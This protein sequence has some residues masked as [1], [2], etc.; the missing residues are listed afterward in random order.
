MGKPS[1]VNTALPPAEYIGGLEASR[2]TETSQYPEERKSTETPRVVASERGSAQTRQVQARRRCLPG[3]VG[4]SALGLR[5]RAGVRKPCASRSV[6]N[7][8][9]QWATVP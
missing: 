6:W 7:V 4:R 8:A 9:P 5:P 1:A 3:V 2:G